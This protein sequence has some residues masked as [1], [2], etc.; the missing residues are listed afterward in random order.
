MPQLPNPKDLQP[1]PNVMS[2]VYSGHS[3]MVRCLSVDPKGQYLL[4]GSD[5]FTIKSV[6]FHILSIALIQYNRD[7]LL[8]N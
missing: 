7:T 8:I 2:L 1:F 6:Y 4:S 3:D 5:D